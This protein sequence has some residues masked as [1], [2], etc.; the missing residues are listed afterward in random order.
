QWGW[1]CCLPAAAEPLGGDAGGRA[2]CI[3]PGGR[4]K[5]PPAARGG[6]GRGEGRP[7]QSHGQRSRGVQASISTRLPRISLLCTLAKS[8]CT[9][10]LR[11]VARGAG[12]CA[13]GHESR[14][15]SSLRVEMPH[16]CSAY[17]ARTSAP[18]TRCESRVAQSCWRMM[19]GILTSIL[20]RFA[21]LSL[22]FHVQVANCSSRQYWLAP[23]IPQLSS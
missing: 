4:L 5:G 15:A 23:T 1:D 7:R 16:A 13:A 19:E 22:M 17:D 8:T 12:D 9:A 18:Y 6:E 14:I 2:V 21:I 3:S 11:G 20:S 10:R